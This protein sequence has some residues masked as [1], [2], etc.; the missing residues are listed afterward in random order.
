M[1]QC[2]E[3]IV[4]EAIDTK[5]QDRLPEMPTVNVRTIAKHLDGMFYTLKRQL[6]AERNRPEVF[7]RHQVYAQC[8]LEEANLNHTIF[9]DEC[10]FNIWTA[11]N[12]GRSQRWDRAYHQVCGHGGRNITICLAISPV[13]GLV[14]HVIQMGGMN[15]QSFNNFLMN[16]SEHSDAHEYITLFFMELQ[17][18]AERRPQTRTRMSKCCHLTRHSLKANVKADLSCPE[19]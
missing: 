7:Q 18:I 12:Y 9:I 15:G 8:F 2:L 5:L 4:N 16:T 13:F 14:H 10:G 1:K 6:P 17:R 19:L 3:A 11:R